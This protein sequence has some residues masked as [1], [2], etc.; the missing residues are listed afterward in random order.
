MLWF[1]WP[2]W[3]IS[4]LHLTRNL[5]ICMLLGILKASWQH[6]S[7]KTN[8]R[9]LLYSILKQL[10]RLITLVNKVKLLRIHCFYLLSSSAK[11]TL[12]PVKSFS[13]SSGLWLNSSRTCFISLSNLW[14][15]TNIADMYQNKTDNQCENVSFDYVPIPHRYRL[16]SLTPKV[17]SRRYSSLVLADTELSKNVFNYSAHML[18]SSSCVIHNGFVV[19]LPGQKK[20]SSN[21]DSIGLVVIAWLTHRHQ[22]NFINYFH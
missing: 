3:C 5:T 6:K 16:Q 1:V 19:F 10:A 9:I 2:P 14:A 18:A 4:S 13:F 17:V 21:S 7:Y 8:S 15:K 11:V 20:N 22:S 12:F